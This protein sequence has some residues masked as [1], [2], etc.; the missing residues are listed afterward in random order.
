MEYTLASPYPVEGLASWQPALGK[1]GAALAAVLAD[2]LFRKRVRDELAAPATF[3][4]FNGEW[5]KVHVV[6]VMQ[7]SHRELEQ[8]SLAELAHRQGKDPLDV[9]LD[10]ALDEDLTTIFT[11]QLLNSDE[12]A[13][14]RLLTHPHSLV[15]LSD[16]G[17]HL[18]FF[19]DAGFGLHLLGH[20]VRERGTMP[21]AEAVRKLTSQPAQIFGLPGRGLLREGFAADLLLFDPA[22]VGRAPSRR[23]FDLPGG[24]P[25]LHTDA[26]GVHGV[27]V[28]G[29]QVA[30]A[31]GLIDGAPLAG[32]VVTRF[33]A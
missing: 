2:P 14:A 27:W 21:L 6:E 10:L 3:R 9:M 17:A 25:R 5:D 15:S 11:A 19:S 7:P 23:V 28:N 20:W 30:D 29:V 18:T 26:L 16:A 24:A 13:V 4:L 12:A 31:G 1:Q 8:R 32:E 33:G 22:T